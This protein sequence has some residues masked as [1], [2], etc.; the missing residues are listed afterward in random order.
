MV[1]YF[2]STWVFDLYLRQINI[3]HLNIN[4]VSPVRYLEHLVFTTMKTT[5]ANYTQIQSQVLST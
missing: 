3:A 4:Q 2:N 1:K 5:L